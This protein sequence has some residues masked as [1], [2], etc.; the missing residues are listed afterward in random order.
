[1]SSIDYFSA[2]SEVSLRTRVPENST[3]TKPFPNQWLSSFC[4]PNSEKEI[5]RAEGKFWKVYY[6]RLQRKK[7]GPWKDDTIKVLVWDLL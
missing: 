6:R 7:E 3:V 2:L 1:M 4:F 5:Q